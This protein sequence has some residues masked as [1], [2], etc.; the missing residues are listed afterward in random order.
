LLTH[1]RKW[2]TNRIQDLIFVRILVLTTEAYGGHGGI[3]LYNR[4]LADALSAIPDIEEVVVVP[5]RQP[6]PAE[7][8]PSGVHFAA[9]AAS[10]AADYVTAVIRFSLKRVDL[11]ICAHVNLLPLAVLLRVK[12]RCPL[13][14]VVYGIDVWTEPHHSTR[15]WLRQVSGVW[16][17]SAI[18][19]DRMNRWARLPATAYTLLPNSIRLDQYGTA[20]KS[21]ELLERYGLHGRKV[22]LT[23]ARMSSAERY[24]GIDEVLEVM[25][26]LIAKEPALSYLV[27]GDGND[28]KRLEAKAHALGVGNHVVFAGFV[29]ECEKADHYRLADVF[30]MPSRGEGFGF[31]FLEALACGVPVVGSALDGSREALRDGELGELVD[32]SDSASVLSGIAR[33]LQKPVAIP[34][35]LAHFSWPAF[36]GR[37]KAAMDAVLSQQ[38]AT[39]LANMGAG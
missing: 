38:T 7:A 10:S 9:R 2:R 19:R 1:A 34:P 26:V 28:R 21:R 33:A 5:R 18:T 8:I 32:P 39:Q 16:S 11:I 37:L 35:G 36:T 15:F 4:D 13:V 27:A 24:K 29:K 12:L 25:P 20:P 6:Q 14:L 3:A 31:V 22:I 23:L 17:I 30:A